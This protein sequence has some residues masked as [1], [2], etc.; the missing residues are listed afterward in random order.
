[1]LSL[2][3]LLPFPH[4][5]SLSITASGEGRLA[6]VHVFQAVMLRLLATVPP[7]KVRFTIID[8]VG[9]GENFAG[10]MHLA[11]YDDILVTNRIWTE[12]QQ[13]EARL[14]DLT[15]HMENVIQ[16]YLRND[17]ETIA[18]YNEFAGEVA[19]PFRVLVVANF[20]ESSPS[21]RPGG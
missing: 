10:F 9:R 14:A 2:P 8:P 1:M 7:G 12:P 5:A 20:P 4:N 11:D 6:A 13:I 19:E 18:E 17:F 16:K 15:E 3:A 21:R